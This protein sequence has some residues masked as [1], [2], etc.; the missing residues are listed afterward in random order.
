MRAT[1]HGGVPFVVQ[2]PYVAFSE[3][4]ML[5]ETAVYYGFLD[6]NLV[7]AA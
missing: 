4:A 6:T 2:G 3:R 1:A 5:S 7:P